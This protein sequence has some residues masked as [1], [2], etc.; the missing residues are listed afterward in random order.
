MSE[1]GSDPL[2][3]ANAV[4]SGTSVHNTRVAF[5]ATTAALGGFLFGFDSAV[6]NGAVFGIQRTFHAS[7]VG[8]GFAVASI[9]IGCAIGALSAGRL[10][11]RVGRRPVMVISAIIFAVT[12]V[13]TAFSGSE[14]MFTLARF[15]SGTA[16]GAASV[17]SPAYTAEISPPSVRGRMASLQQLGIV[18]GIFAALLSDHLLALAAGGANGLLWGGI[19]AWRWMFLVEIG[20][21]VLFGLATIF[22]PESPRY[23]VAAKRERRALEVLLMIDQAATHADVVTIRRTIDADHKPRFADLRSSTGKVLPIVW[24]GTGLSVLQQFVGINSIFYY[25]DV[26]WQSV[27]FAQTDSL[28][29]NVITGVIN[30]V[31]TLV[32]IATIDRVGRR[33]LLTWGS[34]GMAVTLAMLVAA[35]AT[36]SNVGGHLVLS[37][38]MAIVA[39][40]AANLY[41]FAFGMSWGPVVWVLLGEM[42]PNSIRGAAMAAAVFAQWIANW[43]VTISFPPIV[44]AAGPAVAYG[45]YCFFAIV[46]FVFVRRWVRE[47]KG[48]TLEAATV[49]A[50]HAAAVVPVVPVTP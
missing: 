31:A 1:P 6:V 14:W 22:I 15:V 40:V 28:R 17:V 19:E 27:G 18:T 44:T 34:L 9:L 29:N 33:P 42:F 7:S 45:T 5:F 35:F 41:V 3:P 8:T 10:A 30:I 46:S 47:T 21:S 25:G 32:A 43:L 36:A 20:P 13:W 38:P 2:P 39:L 48:Q 4:A 24:I 23:L 37:R 26:L 49:G 16:V 12:A 11:D 50:P